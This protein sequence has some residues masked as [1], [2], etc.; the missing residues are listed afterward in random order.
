V[1]DSVIVLLVKID[2][3]DVVKDAE[4]VSLDSVRIRSLPQNLQEGGVRDKEEPRE[5]QPLLLEVA[6][7]R[8]LT[9]LQLLQQ[10]REKLTESL[11][12]NATNDNV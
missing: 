1:C 11:V 8:F 4:E 10:V 7:E 2:C 12:A 6:S 9:E 3:L 5:D